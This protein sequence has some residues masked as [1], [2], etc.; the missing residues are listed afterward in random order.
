MIPPPRFATCLDRQRS[1]T[2]QGR[3]TGAHASQARRRSG[4]SRCR[5]RTSRR[6]SSPS[7]TSPAPATSPSGGRFPSLVVPRCTR[8]SARNPDSLHRLTPKDTPPVSPHLRA[9][10]TH[11]TEG[12][13]RQPNRMVGPPLGVSMNTRGANPGLP[14]PGTTARCSSCGRCRPPG[15]WPPCRLASPTRSVGT[16]RGLG[17][18]RQF[19]DT[20][21]EVE[22]YHVVAR[23][24]TENSERS[25]RN[26]DRPRRRMLHC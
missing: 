13:P 8:P 17:P 16:G 1:H 26:T 20:D 12:I 23:S 18:C 24:Q 7:T 4:A 22:G 21:E 14:S 9:Y 11:S 19:A 2:T 15:S 3:T 25:H 5:R 10:P 6:S